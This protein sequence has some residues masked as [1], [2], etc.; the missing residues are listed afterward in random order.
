MDSDYNLIFKY[1]TLIVCS[2]KWSQFLTNIIIVWMELALVLHVIPCNTFNSIV[3][4]I[5]RM[6]THSLSLC[7][8]RADIAKTVG[9]SDKSDSFGQNPN[10]WEMLSVQK[11]ERIFHTT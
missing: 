9:S 2:N 3:R 1:Q 11:S 5:C 4:L 7:I 10:G 6:Y 8:S